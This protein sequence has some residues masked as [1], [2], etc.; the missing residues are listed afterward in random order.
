MAP[1]TYENILRSRIEQVCRLLATRVEITNQQISQETGM[2]P[3]T[4]C[5]VM[6]GL[7]RCGICVRI[8]R[9]CYALGFVTSGKSEYNFQI[10]GLDSEPDRVRVCL[11]SG[12]SEFFWLSDCDG[13]P[14]IQEFGAFTGV[15]GLV[16]KKLSGKEQLEVWKQQ[17][18]SV[19]KK[20]RSYFRGET[21]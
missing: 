20:I 9:G 12:F 6:D 15:A 8:H 3:S 17:N 13:L 1:L 4:T 16:S 11:G 18:Q 19:W 5:R 7:I 10:P 14:S 2:H 21:S